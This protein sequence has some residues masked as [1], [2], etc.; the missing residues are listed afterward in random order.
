MSLVLNHPCLSVRLSIMYQG[1][2]QYQYGLCTWIISKHCRLLRIRSLTHESDNSNNCAEGKPKCGLRLNFKKLQP[3]CAL[4]TATNRLVVPRFFS[5]FY[6][7]SSPLLDFFFLCHFS[8]AS[9]PAGLHPE[10]KSGVAEVPPLGNLAPTYTEECFKTMPL[11]P[12]HFPSL[13]MSH[14]EFGRF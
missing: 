9:S 6:L 14:L 13:M 2:S 12:G 1:Y 7:S 10:R 11:R 5:C 8:V 3:G 4:D